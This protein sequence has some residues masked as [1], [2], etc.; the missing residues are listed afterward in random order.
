MPLNLDKYIGMSQVIMQD[1]IK[2]AQLSFE[3]FKEY[4][5]IMIET[6]LLYK[7]EETDDKYLLLA[8]TMFTYWCRNMLTCLKS[9]DIIE[10]YKMYISEYI[11]AF[12][13]PWLYFDACDEETWNEKLTKSE[14]AEENHYVLQ[15]YLYHIRINTVIRQ[16]DAVSECC[17]CMVADKDT[18]FIPCGHY[19][20]CHTCAV[21]SKKCPICRVPG[22][23]FLK[24]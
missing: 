13:Y 24:A 10:L 15:V 17:V 8:Q 12:K 23:R 7:F 1:E 2:P 6:E 16:D 20:T 21:T 19:Y 3:I 5:K 9:Y 4:L 18:I 22:V 14:Y 11:Y